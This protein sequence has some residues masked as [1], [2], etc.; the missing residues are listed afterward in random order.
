LSRDEGLRKEERMNSKSI[1][2]VVSVSV[3]VLALVGLLLW[4]GAAPPVRA[5]P[6]TR[7]VAPD[8]DDSK[9]CDSISNRCRTIQRAIDVSGTGDG[10]HV[11]GGTYTSAI[12]TVAVITKELVLEGGY[13]LDFSAHDP[14]L[15]QTVLDAQWGGSVIS[16]TNAGDV[17]LHFLTLTHGDGAGN[18]SIGIS[19]G[20]CGGGIHAKDTAVHIGHCVITDN[21]GSS[22]GYGRGGGI[23]IDNRNSYKPADIWEGQIVSNTATIS[24]TAVGWGGGLWLQAGSHI[25]PATVM[26][27]TFED[28]TAN[29]AGE[30][31]GGG[32]FLWYYATL[33]NNLFRYNYGSRATTGEG[34]GGALYLWEVDGVTLEA[35]RFLSNT[36]SVSSYGYGGA[37]YG[38][39]NVAFTMTNNLLAENHASTAGGG[40]WLDTWQPSYLIAGTLVNNTLADNDAGA[41]GEGIWAGRYVSLTLTN[42]LISGHTVGITVTAPAS[43]TVSADT[44]LFY[45]DSDPITGT[46]AILEDPL[47]TANYHPGSGSPAIDAGLTIPWLTV[48]LE[49]NPRPQGAKYD[50]GAFEKV[51]G[52][53]YLPLILKGY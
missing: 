40:L 33:S 30:G 45:N 29:T 14:D 11:S 19:I 51:E 12:G 4:L 9:M 27:T 37:I 42:T 6:A 47:L 34:E 25:T 13:A 3:G 39:A 23:Y 50:I 5:D 46:N 43:S 7:Y 52:K 38:S 10:I 20:G 2:A 1:R 26:S 32:V 16:I 21:V 17:L 48:D 22:T 15:Y 41:G 35:N 18:C 8:G 28:N 31:Q 53:V 24:D 49:G 44:N 36:A